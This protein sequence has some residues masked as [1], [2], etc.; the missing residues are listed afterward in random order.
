MWRIEAFSDS[1]KVR[2]RDGARGA[3]V[4]GSRGG[5]VIEYGGAVIC[6]PVGDAQ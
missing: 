2:I 3:A 6:L 1:V 4:G 5:D